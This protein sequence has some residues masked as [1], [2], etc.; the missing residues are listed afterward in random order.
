MPPHPHKKKQVEKGW[1]VLS[2]IF[3]ENTTLQSNREGVW[4]AIKY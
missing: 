1:M 2:Q 3:L 4:S